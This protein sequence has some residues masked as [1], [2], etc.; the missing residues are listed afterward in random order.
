MYV[1]S[2]S[3]RAARV[4]M[5]RPIP[6][7]RDCS[8]SRRV[9]YSLS[10][11]AIWAAVRSGRFRDRRRLVADVRLVER[12]RPRGC[13]PGEH[14][15]VP[16]GRGGRAVPQGS[17]PCGAVGVNCRKNGWASFASARLMKSTAF[18]VSTSVR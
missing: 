18:A 17:A 9:W 13:R 15:D 1:L 2:S 8:D 16:R 7:S 5:I 4:S 11:A 10:M 6:S 3:P 12:R 14:P